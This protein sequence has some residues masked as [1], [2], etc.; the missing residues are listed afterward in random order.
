[1]PEVVERELE[2]K[3][4]KVEV[5]QTCM[6]GLASLNNRKARPDFAKER[7]GEAKL[8]HL[9]KERPSLSFMEV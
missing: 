4:V 5:S 3:K 1:M 2:V 9:E 8:R 7:V 6:R